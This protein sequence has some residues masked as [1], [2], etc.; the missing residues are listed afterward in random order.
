M[1]FFV[2]FIQVTISVIVGLLLIISIYQIVARLLFKQDLPL[3]LGYGNAVVISGSME[4][5]ISVGDMIIVKAEDNYKIGDVVVYHSNRSL[6]THQIVE[7]NE[8]GYVT[9]GIANNVV[10]PIVKS[11]Q[12]VGKVVFVID[13]VGYIVDFLQSPIGLIGIILLGFLLIEVP[14][15]LKAKKNEKE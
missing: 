12:V 15:W 2:K 4:P 1:R 13:G 7:I 10:D 11:K 5:E 9:K 8:N 6:I 3:F 14:H